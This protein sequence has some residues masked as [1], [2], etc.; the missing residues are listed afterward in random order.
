[1]QAAGYAYNHVQ[2][3]RLHNQILI[4]LHFTIRVKL[5]PKKVYIERTFA[6]RIFVKGLL[7]F[8]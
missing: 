4:T 3:G 5:Y 2:V 7:E 1:M 8:F 6:F